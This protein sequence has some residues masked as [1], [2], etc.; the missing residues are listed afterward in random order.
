MMQ[1]DHEEKRITNT[2]A[3]KMTSSKLLVTAK[4]NGVVFELLILE[5]NITGF[6]GTCYYAGTALQP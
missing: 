4:I 1:R 6:I 3:H 2:G 5:V